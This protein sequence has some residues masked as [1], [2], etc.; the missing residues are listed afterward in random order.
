LEK[1][2]EILD[3]EHFVNKRL[4]LELLYIK[5][6]KISLN[7]QTDIELLNKAYIFVSNTWKKCFIYNYI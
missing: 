6:Q 4:I 2:R 3:E 1:Y 5:R 7:L